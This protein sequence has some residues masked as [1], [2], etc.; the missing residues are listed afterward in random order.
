MY[1]EILKVCVTIQLKKII[2]K[3]KKITCVLVN[4]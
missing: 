1:D 3:T 4:L 2:Y